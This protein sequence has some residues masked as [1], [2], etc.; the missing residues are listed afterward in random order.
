MAQQGKRKTKSNLDSIHNKNLKVCLLTSCAFS[1]L[2]VLQDSIMCWRPFIPTH[3]HYLTTYLIELSPKQTE[4][5]QEKLF[6]L[7]GQ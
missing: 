5:I 1:I 4:L 6:D 2:L 7:Y 3:K